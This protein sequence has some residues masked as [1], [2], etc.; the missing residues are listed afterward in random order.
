MDLVGTTDEVLKGI[1]AKLNGE[2][3]CKITDPSYM[4]PVGVERNIIK[5]D[6]GGMAV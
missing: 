4:L 1:H 3:E 2:W 5:D 6:D